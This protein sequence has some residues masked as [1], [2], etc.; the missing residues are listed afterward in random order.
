MGLEMEGQESKAGLLLG[1]WHV[2]NHTGSWNVPGGWGGL[3]VGIARLHD[4]AMDDGL[5][6]G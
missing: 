4:G 1:S 2:G 5:S 3:P 6:L